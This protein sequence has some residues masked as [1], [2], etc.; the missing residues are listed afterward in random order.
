[1][2]LHLAQLLAKTIYRAMHYELVVSTEYLPYNKN[3]IPGR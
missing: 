2:S 3:I 1:M